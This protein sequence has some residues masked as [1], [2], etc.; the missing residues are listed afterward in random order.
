[1]F[2]SFIVIVTLLKCRLRMQGLKNAN[3]VLRQTFIHLIIYTMGKFASLSD[4]DAARASLHRL[5]PRTGR[6]HHESS[7]DGLLPSK[8]STALQFVLV[9][10]KESFSFRR[11]GRTV[12]PFLAGCAL[13]VVVMAAPMVSDAWI[14]DASIGGHLHAASG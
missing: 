8:Q 12:R 6:S 3:F 13:A 1:M 4:N 9:E 14:E 11:R 10:D 2:L 5:L 7:I